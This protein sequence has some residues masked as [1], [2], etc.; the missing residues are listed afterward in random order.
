MYFKYSSVNISAVDT[1][2]LYNRIGTGIVQNLWLDKY[3]RWVKFGKSGVPSV[4]C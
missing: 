4:S 3:S 1:P 2:E